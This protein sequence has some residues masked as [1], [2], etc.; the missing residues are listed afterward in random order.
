MIFYTLTLKIQK[1]A[2]G[3]HLKVWQDFRSLFKTF[4]YQS[5]Q[6][7]KSEFKS[8][9]YNKYATENDAYYIFISNSSDFLANIKIE[10][11]AL[12]GKAEGNEK[13]RLVFSFE[14]GKIVNN[15]D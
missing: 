14:F 15:I 7:D 3:R 4:I 8:L 11:E 13:G 1:R 12:I 9:Q 10:M 6:D 2:N 5:Q